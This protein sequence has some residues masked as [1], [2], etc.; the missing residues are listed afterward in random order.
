VFLDSAA[1]QRV[2]QDVGGKVDLLVV[3]PLGV[4]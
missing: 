4:G 2:T 1:Q 3:A